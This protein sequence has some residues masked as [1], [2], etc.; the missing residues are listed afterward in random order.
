MTRY[1][2]LEIDLRKLYINSKII[3][4]LCNDRGISVAGVIKGFGGIREG[5]KELINGGCAQIASSRI[6]QLIDIKKMDMDI[7]LLLL[8][9]PME[10]EIESVIKF[11]HMSLVS[12]IETIVFL[13]REAK[14]QGI[15]YRVILMYDVG[16]LR[17]GFFDKAELLNTALFVE[18][19][20]EN[21]ILEGVGTSLTCYGSVIPTVKNLG[22]L[23]HAAELIEERIGR[24]LNIISGGSTTSLPLVVD[25]TIPEKINHLRIGEAISCAKYLED[26][27][28][29][30]IEGIHKDAFTLK[31]QIIEI[32]TK[33]TYPIGERL[34]NSFGDEV[35]YVDLGIRKRAIVAMGNQDVGDCFKIY[36]RD[37]YI[38]VM[39]GSSDH[40]IL[41]IHDSPIDYKVGDIVEFDIEYQPMLFTSLSDY[42]H[43][44]FI[45]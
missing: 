38:R 27:Q 33:P 39:G 21:L 15:E 41:D 3:N 34:L 14:K 4:K 13:N 23:C 7:P 26:E 11:T 44:S 5:V 8:R 1:P 17:E 2:L 30:K 43:K 12:D 24:R 31:A 40:I 20:M 10:S 32:N 16:D 22:Q 36:P 18:R 9:N 25:G 19:E 29:C 35:E 6:E 45:P 37:P 42:V 28:G